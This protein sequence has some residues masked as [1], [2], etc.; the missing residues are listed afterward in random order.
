MT[1]DDKPGAASADKWRETFEQNQKETDLA[2]TRLEIRAEQRSAPDVEEDSAVIHKE[3]LQRV[4]AREVDTDA[5]PSKASPTVIVLTV[6]RKLP[7]PALMF[8]GVAGLAAY[9]F[10]KLHGH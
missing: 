10:L 7:W 9:V 8:L 5:P 6:V 2:L 1:G 3:A 4:A